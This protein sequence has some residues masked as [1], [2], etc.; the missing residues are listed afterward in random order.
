MNRILYRFVVTFYQ[1]VEIQFVEVVSPVAK[2]MMTYR[3]TFHKDS[4][5]QM[6]VMKI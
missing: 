5:A 4:L 6:A 3:R 1:I 2:A